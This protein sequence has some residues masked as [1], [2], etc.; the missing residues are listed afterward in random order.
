M[1][2]P[3]NHDDVKFAFKIDSISAIIR[4]ISKSVNFDD[5]E[6]HFCDTLSLRVTAKLLI[7]LPEV[8]VAQLLGKQ[9]VMSHRFNGVAP[10]H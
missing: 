2:L 4:G 9:G 3:S 6:R 5:A 1:R 10:W 7:P 8:L